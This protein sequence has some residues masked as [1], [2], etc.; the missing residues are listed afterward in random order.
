MR[1]PAPLPKK[2]EEPPIFGL[3]LLWPNSW[4]EQDATWY[5]GRPRS[6]PYCARC[7]H[8]STPHKRGHS[9]EFSAHICCGQTAGWIKMP[10]GTKVGL[11]PGHIVLHHYMGTRLFPPPKK[12]GTAPNFG[13]RLLWPNGRP[14]WLLLST[15][16][17]GAILI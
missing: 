14:S 17:G 16:L 4:M 10:L 8:S 9:P 12:R 13:P 1:D 11:G 5:G 3:C 6:V 15:C 2:E 7:G